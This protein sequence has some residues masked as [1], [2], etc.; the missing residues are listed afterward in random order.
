[1]HKHAHAIFLN[2]NFND[3]WWIVA[4]NTTN[5]FRIQSPHAAL[6]KIPYEAWYYARLMLKHIKTIGLDAWY[7]LHNTIKNWK[8]TFRV[9]HARLIGFDGNH[10]YC[11][12][13]DDGKFVKSLNVH[14]QERLPLASMKCLM[15]EEVSVYLNTEHVMK[16]KDFLSQGKGLSRAIGILLVLNST[17]N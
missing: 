5:Y 13:I 6:N 15:S 9:A 2:S 3:C 16:R 7:K 12:M 10:I 4:F 17:S 8:F 14:F 1:M 11:L